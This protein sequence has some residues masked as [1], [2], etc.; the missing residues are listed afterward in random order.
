MTIEAGVGAGSLGV[1][2]GAGGGG[3][4]AGSGVSTTNKVY[5][6]IRSYVDNS[7]ASA[8]VLS[9]GSLSVTSNNTS[10][11]TAT[12]GSVSLALAGGAG[13]GVSI[14]VGVSWRL[15]PLMWIPA[16]I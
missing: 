16:P 15:I 12:A 7:G 5:G 3:A 4:G 8:K 6:D 10:K 11:I 2:G 9:V 14:S 1:A 13:G